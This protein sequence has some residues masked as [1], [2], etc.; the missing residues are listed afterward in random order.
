MFLKRNTQPRLLNSHHHRLNDDESST[1][2]STSYKD[3]SLSWANGCSSSSSSVKKA[4]SQQN[5]FKQQPVA[6]KVSSISR[7]L[8]NTKTT[9]II[10]KED[11]IMIYIDD[12]LSILH[13]LDPQLHGKTAIVKD[14]IG[15]DLELELVIEDEEDFTRHYNDRIVLIPAFVA[16]LEDKVL[17][18]RLERFGAG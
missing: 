5:I 1:I 8:Y 18:R 13:S 4:T 2:Y 10:K 17:K 15:D 9:K 7:F 6:K 11:V 16:C 12:D 3:R 14:I